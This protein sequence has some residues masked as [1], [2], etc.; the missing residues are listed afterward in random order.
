MNNR[1]IAITAA[2]MLPLFSLQGAAAYTL[3]AQPARVEI[4]LA[5]FSFTPSTIKLVAGKPVTLHFVNRGSGGHDFTAKKFFAAAQMD[6]ATRK[7]V[8]KKGRID[9]ARGQS[10]DITL[11]PKAGVYKVKCAHF[12]H[13]SFGMKGSVTV[14]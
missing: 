5:N 12:L 1:L 7:Q 11:T 14:R 10:M 3:A 13:A 9:L 8:G 2:A 6:A 4:A